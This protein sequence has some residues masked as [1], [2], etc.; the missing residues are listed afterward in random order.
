MCS[1]DLRLPDAEKAYRKVLELTPQ[2]TGAH[3]V[4]AIILS[5]QGRHEEALAELS[6][7]PASWARLTGL[8][9]VH[10]RAGHQQEADEALRE[11]ES[12]HGVDSAYQ[13][14]AVRAARGEAD[15]A[16]HWFERALQEHDYGL[17]QSRSEPVFR[18]LH[19]DPRWKALMKK[20]GH[21]A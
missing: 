17:A 19:G 3:H 5:D 10:Y 2:R 6:R 7:E 20:L 14:A 11:L 13:I 18:P 4:L 1:S 15:A 21:D 16:F 12:K 9:Y 8:S